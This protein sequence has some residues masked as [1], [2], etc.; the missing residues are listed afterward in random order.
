MRRLALNTFMQS[1][2]RRFTFSIPLILGIA[3]AAIFLP[4]MLFTVKAEH[5]ARQAIENYDPFTLPDFRIKISKTM[6]WDSLGVLGRGNQAGFWQWTPTGIVLVDKGRPYFSDTPETI[7]CLVGAGRRQVTKIERY[8]DAG[9]KRDVR[10]LYR[11]TE[12]TPPAR[13]LLS[14]PPDP[15]RDYDGHAILVKANNQWQVEWMETPHFDK[16]MA[17]LKD[18]VQQIKR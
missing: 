13:A 2:G 9:G 4:W 3:V 10:F 12:V 15:D 18:E 6:T 1:S 5:D 17:L 16:P 14:S 7:V 11:W 8:K